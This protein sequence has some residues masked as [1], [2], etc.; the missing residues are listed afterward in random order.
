MVSSVA[1]S[2]GIDGDEI[3]DLVDEGVRVYLEK[4]VVI[5]TFVI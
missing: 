4:T 2:D 5:R 1:T 3:T